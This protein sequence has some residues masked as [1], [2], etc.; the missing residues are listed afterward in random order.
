[1]GKANESLVFYG[2]AFKSSISHLIS[3]EMM[4]QTGTGTI[5]PPSRPQQDPEIPFQANPRH[6][7][8]EMLLLPTILSFLPWKKMV[9]LMVQLIMQRASLLRNRNITGGKWVIA[10]ITLLLW[11]FWLLDMIS[12]G[13][14]ASFLPGSRSFI[15]RTVIGECS[16]LKFGMIFFVS[17]KVPHLLYHLVP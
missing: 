14:C 5:S 9:A 3:R 16:L 17:L 1:M 7:A 15:Y 4:Q 6:W 8:S 13:L 11:N 10:K 2:W 12:S